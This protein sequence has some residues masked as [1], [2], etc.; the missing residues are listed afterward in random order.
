[1]GSIEEDTGEGDKRE[2]IRG[3]RIIGG[4]GAI[5][6][7]ISERRRQEDEEKGDEII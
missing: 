3:V 7:R 5:K 1:M 6:K 4:E 2:E